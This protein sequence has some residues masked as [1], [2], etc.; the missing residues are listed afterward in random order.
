MVKLL[1]HSQFNYDTFPNNH[2]EPG[3]KYID[4][5]QDN[6]VINHRGGI[7]LLLEPRS[8]IGS[9]YEY[10]ENHASD[11]D[12]IFTHD[13]NLLKFNNAHLLIWA[14]V[15]CT[16]DSPKTKGISLVSSAKDWCP[17]HKARLSL[18][19]LFEKSSKVDT[20]GDFN[21]G[22]TVGAKEAH[23]HYKFAIIIE[24]D[25]DD[26]WI[27]EKVFNCFATKTVPI[28]LG[29]KLEEFNQDG[30]I[31]VNDWVE[32]PS[33]VNELDLDSYE[34]YLPAVNDN[35]KRVEKYKTGWLDRF[36]NDYGEL[37]EDLWRKL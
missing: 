15:W 10:V 33:I 32:I 5:W 7:A 18:A 20:F 6:E 4:V 16:T 23:E 13:S 3:E 1:T 29:G 34:K 35:F 31:R 19:K 2:P 27:T 24:N 30:I 8:L 37:L 12:L 21:G 28:Y 14:S 17:L 11:Y 22:P 25:V 36:F 26:N 9:A